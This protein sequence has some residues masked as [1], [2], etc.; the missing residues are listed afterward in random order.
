MLQSLLQPFARWGPIYTTRLCKEVDS[1]VAIELT[2]GGE[3]LRELADRRMTLRLTRCEAVMGHDG[4]AASGCP[5][6]A[7]DRLSLGPPFSR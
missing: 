3:L 7:R 1:D 2:V 6:R 4:V 5:V